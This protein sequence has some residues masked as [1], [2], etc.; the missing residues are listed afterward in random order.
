MKVIGITGGI[1]AGKSELLSYISAHYRCRIILS[2]QV[3][4]EVKEKGT[5]CYDAIVELLGKSVLDTDGEINRNKMAARI[6]A[7]RSLLVKVN[8]IL[9]PA[10]NT[11]IMDAIAEEREKNETDYLF[12]EA[13]LL[14]ESGYEH[15]VDRM[16]YIYAPDEIRRKRLK[17]SRGYSDEKITKILERQLSED[18]FRA[19]CDVV[20]D[21]GADLEHAYLQIDKELEGRIG[22]EPG[23][24]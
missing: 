6:F 19:H 20:I 18:E 17:E 14:I 23:T 2:D 10:V 22:G 21:N 11:F 8:E 24:K 1:G 7:D 4:N 13:A 12:I 15:V 9:H 16:W 3:A 5:A